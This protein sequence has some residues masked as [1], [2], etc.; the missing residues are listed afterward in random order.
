ML[1]V[2][3]G[4]R[5]ATCDGELDETS[6]IEVPVSI[7][8]HSGSR[9]APHA[10]LDQQLQICRTRLV[11]PEAEAQRVIEPVEAEILAAARIVPVQKRAMLAM[12]GIRHSLVIG[13]RG[14][15]T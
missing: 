6:V 10:P 13:S 4:R 11:P 7:D 1:V 14:D 3:V 12:L 8:P 9:D 5:R 15:R 2:F